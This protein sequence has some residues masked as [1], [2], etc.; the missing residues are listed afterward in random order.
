VERTFH[1]GIVSKVHKDRL[2]KKIE[3]L[4]TQTQEAKAMKETLKNFDAV[5]EKHETVLK[6][7]KARLEGS[8]ADK[9]KMNERLRG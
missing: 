5:R 7:L 8:E 9:V 4:F 3:H 1:G 2:T 6:E